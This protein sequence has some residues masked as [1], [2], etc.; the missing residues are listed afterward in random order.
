MFAEL[1]KAGDKIMIYLTVALKFG[2]LFSDND[3][4]DP[5]CQVVTR[6]SRVHRN[7]RAVAEARDVTLKGT[8][9]STPNSYPIQDVN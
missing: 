8:I 4:S 6:R 2:C 1:R 9:K 3:L 5:N 7:G